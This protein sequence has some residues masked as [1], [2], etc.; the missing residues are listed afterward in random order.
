MADIALKDFI[1]ARV[2]ESD[3]NPRNMHTGKTPDEVANTAHDDLLKMIKAEILFDPT[4]RGYAG[5]T[6]QHIADL[7]NS[8]YEVDVEEVHV[9]SARMAQITRK[10]LEEEPVSQENIV[11]DG[12]GNVTVGS[13]DL[14]TK[15]AEAIEKEINEDPMNYGY[16]GKT[17]EEIYALL[18]TARAVTIKRSV[19]M[20]SRLNDISVDIA[21]IPNSITA[22]TITEA[23]KISDTE[24]QEISV[25]VSQPKG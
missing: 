21:F 16:K 19:T 13:I 25:P 7:I 4:N 12:Q 1:K 24:V 9:E 18:R 5:K 22:Q 6:D 3:A 20:P 17:T 8:S 2:Q 11:I 10:V 15:I 23:K 14:Q